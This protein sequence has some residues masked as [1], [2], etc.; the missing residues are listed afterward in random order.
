MP[1]IRLLVA[2]PFLVLALL[3]ILAC[4]TASTG[5]NTGVIVVGTVTAPPA[6][7]HFKVG[8]QVKVGSTWL[9]VV[10][11]VK[12]STGDDVFQPASGNIYVVVDVTL[13]NLSNQ[14][15][16]VSS[17][18][19][20][21][22]KDATGQEYTESFTDIGKPPDG[23]IAPADLLRGQ[24]VYEVSASQKTFTLAFQASI[25]DSSVTIWDIVV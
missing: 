3:I 8:Q 25:V 5:G 17:V 22:F 21:T 13:K 19:S 14:P 23:T 11:S 16:D 20:F 4:G 1:R 18:A 24:L 12:T 7:T 6:Q 2:A 15:Q 9:I 10:N